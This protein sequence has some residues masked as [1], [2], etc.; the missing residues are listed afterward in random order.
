MA[1]C[2]GG[3]TQHV[4]QGRGGACVR[5][6]VYLDV[7]G[8]SLGAG[9]VSNPPRSILD[10][11]FRYVPS[12]KTDVAA[13]VRRIRRELEAQ[14]AETQKVVTPIAKGKK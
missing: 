8:V 5:A 1:R 14:K 12:A 11:R 9:A 3:S 13:T 2:A 6:A 10:P 7:G 4:A